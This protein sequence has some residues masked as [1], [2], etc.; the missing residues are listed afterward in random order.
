MSYIKLNLF[1]FLRNS[2][3]LKNIILYI[4]V[5]NIPLVYITLIQDIYMKIQNS[6]K[7]QNSSQQKIKVN[8]LPQY[9]NYI[10]LKRR[11][12]RGALP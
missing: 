2:I 8:M 4:S 7:A 5:N 9:Q 6:T 10:E 11:H 1:P 3:F 12:H